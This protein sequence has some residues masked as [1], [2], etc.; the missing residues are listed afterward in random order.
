[1]IPWQLRS[2]ITRPQTSSWET[3][4]PTAEL[5]RAALEERIRMGPETRRPVE[6]RLAA[7]AAGS[8][9]LDRTAALAE[10]KRAVAAAESLAREYQA[11]RR[12][13]KAAVAE[14]RR[15]FPWLDTGDSGADL[16]AKLGHFG[17]YLVI[18]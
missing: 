7:R 17:Y 6:E 13:Q 12:S 2:S 9:D 3:T 14:L 16:A 5:L 10:A 15:L 1:L 18:M 11:N 8:T 4:I